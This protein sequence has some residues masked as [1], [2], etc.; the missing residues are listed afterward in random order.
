MECNHFFLKKMIELDKI[1]IKFHT[2]EINCDIL[3][4][5]LILEVSNASAENKFNAFRVKGIF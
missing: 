2:E 5:I 1:I 4:N 3:R